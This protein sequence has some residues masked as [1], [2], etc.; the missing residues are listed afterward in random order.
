MKKDC[1]SDEMCHFISLCVN[2]LLKRYVDEVRKLT[3]EV[4]F[5]SKTDE[6]D[7]YIELRDE[8][9]FMMDTVSHI[10]K[11]IDM[12]RDGPCKDR[13]KRSEQVDKAY[14]RMLDVD[15]ADVDKDVREK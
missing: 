10:I 5:L 9:E 4:R 11:N 13:W 15:W 14:R 6:Y 7:T 3:Q 1:L 12:L 2:D 8:V